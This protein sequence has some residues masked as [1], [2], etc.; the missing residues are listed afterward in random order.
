MSGKHIWIDYFGFLKLVIAQSFQSQG[1]RDYVISLKAYL[2]LIA[3][4]N[5]WIE[6]DIC[7]LDIE[8]NHL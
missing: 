3:K 4:V 7:Q 8:P 2:L 6:E 5:W 1:A